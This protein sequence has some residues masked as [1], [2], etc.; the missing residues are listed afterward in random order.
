MIEIRKD[1]LEELRKKLDRA[2]ELLDED[3]ELA[4]TKAR[5]VCVNLE[6]EVRMSEGE[7][8]KERMKQIR[9]IENGGN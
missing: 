8:L 9:W 5:E 4:R 6:T 2:I 1:A 3:E 7:E